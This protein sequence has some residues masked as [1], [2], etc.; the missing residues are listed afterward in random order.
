MKLIEVTI[1]DALKIC[2]GNMQEKVLV[3][4]MDLEDEEGGIADFH[5]T[6]KVACNKIIRESKT[7]ARM[8]DDFISGLECFSVKQDVRRI[9]PRGRSHTILLVQ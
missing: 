6:D 2:N 9:E 1:K 7:V 5:S 4:V 8:C 3:A